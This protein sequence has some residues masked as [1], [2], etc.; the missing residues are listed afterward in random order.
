MKTDYAPLPPPVASS[1]CATSGDPTPLPE[2][3]LILLGLI[4][5]VSDIMGNGI[6]LPSCQI[7]A[8]CFVVVVVKVYLFLERASMSTGG[9]GAERGRERIPSRLHTVSSEPH[10][11]WIP[12]T[13]RS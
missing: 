13:V 5:E 10:V 4:M 1:W 3:S 12:Q 9:G 6:G 2:V 7:E 8:S 11:G